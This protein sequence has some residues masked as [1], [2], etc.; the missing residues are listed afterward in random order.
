MAEPASEL[1]GSISYEIVNLAAQVLPSWQS[2]GRVWPTALFER[3]G[4]DVSH[5]FET[6]AALFADLLRDFPMLQEKMRTTIHFNYSL[7]GYV[8]PEKQGCWSSCCRS[9]AARSS[10]PGTKTPAAT[11]S[12]HSRPTTR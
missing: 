10:S 4:V 1:V 8:P 5:V 9:T 11:T 3:I 12:R 7:G 2:R 6:P